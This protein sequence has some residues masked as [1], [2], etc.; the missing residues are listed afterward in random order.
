MA[1][2]VIAC[3]DSAAVL[4]PID[5]PLDDITSFVS[6]GVKARWC[7]AVASL[8]QPIFLRIAAFRA[9]TTDTPLLDL[10]SLFACA[11]S[12]VH[13]QTEGAL[14]GSATA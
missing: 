10:F 4:E 13:A 7:A 14:A 11:I 5:G 6:D 2:F 3:C 8:M 12:A 1:A 9:D